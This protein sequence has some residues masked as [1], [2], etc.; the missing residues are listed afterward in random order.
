MRND[1]MF[2][3][4]RDPDLAMVQIELSPGFSLMNFQ[5]PKRN[6]QLRNPTLSSE[7]LDNELRTPL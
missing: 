5:N 2:D 1:F 7:T 6:S 4:Q 3:L